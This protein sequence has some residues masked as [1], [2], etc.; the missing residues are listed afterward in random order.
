MR[1]GTRELMRDQTMPDDLTIMGTFGDSEL[2][3]LSM[4][5]SYDPAT[6]K[7]DAITYDAS[8]NLTVNGQ[9]ASPPLTTQ[10]G[11][12]ISLDGGKLSIETKGG[13]HFSMES[14]I[15]PAL[16]FEGT[17][18]PNRGTDAVHSDLF[19]NFDDNPNSTWVARQDA[20]RNNGVGG[21]GP[22]GIG[23]AGGATLGSLFLDSILEDLRKTFAS[24]AKSGT[25]APLPDDPGVAFLH[26]VLDSQLREAI[27]ARAKAG[28]ID[29]DRL[30]D[31]LSD[32]EER[33]KVMAGLASG[34][35]VDIAIAQITRPEDR[36]AFLTE[37]VGADH[38]DR[39]MAKLFPAP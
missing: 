38:V 31:T 21:A 32:P 10:N 30:K 20:N 35:F 1:S 15:C 16:N 8:G 6:G 29:V 36:K 12:K 17:L 19:G 4:R 28:S 33:A 18:N 25:G 14:T 3:S 7:G 24:M 26:R 9:P 13:D 34:G 2:K 23:A 37:L 11:T 5:V 39:M 22:G 27:L